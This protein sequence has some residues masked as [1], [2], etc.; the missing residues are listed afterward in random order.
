MSITELL[1]QMKLK[2]SSTTDLDKQMKALRGTEEY[3]NAMRH[4]LQIFKIVEYV[5][6]LEK[7]LKNGGIV[8]L[9]KEGDFLITQMSEILKD[10]F[11]ESMAQYVPEYMSPTPE[12]NSWEI[13]KNRE[14]MTEDVITSIEKKYPWIETIE[15]RCNT[16]REN[17]A[18]IALRY[19]DMISPDIG[20]IVEPAGKDFEKMMSLPQISP[21]PEMQALTKINYEEEMRKKHQE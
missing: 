19:F 20:K 17:K 7:N 4:Y 1:E 12:K 15:K 2:K 5:E 6:C 10:S 11:E 16:F 21:I 13:N 8:A 9:K 14:K 18:I 3:K